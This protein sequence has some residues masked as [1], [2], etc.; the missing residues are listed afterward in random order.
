ME[1]RD[2]KQLLTELEHT[3]LFDKSQPTFTKN[4]LA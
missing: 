4:T 1:R 2:G 3:V